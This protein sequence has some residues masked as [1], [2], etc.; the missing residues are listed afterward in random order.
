MFRK[1]SRENWNVRT[2]VSLFKV[3]SL[4]LCCLILAD[5][6]RFGILDIWG[7]EIEE[8]GYLGKM[9]VYWALGR[10]IWL[11]EELRT[12]LL[13]LAFCLHTVHIVGIC[14]KGQLMA[15]QNIFI[16][17][18]YSLRRILVPANYAIVCSSLFFLSA[19][20][21]IVSQQG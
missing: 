17:R 11:F 8:F 6:C 15:M 16:I 1:E 4:C 19:V 20:V 18:E 12:Y 2:P 14:Y 21:K 3:F 7:G 13:I 9:E 10:Q 5:S